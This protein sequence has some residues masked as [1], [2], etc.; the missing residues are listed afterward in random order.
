MGSHN[1]SVKL[2]CQLIVRS[3]LN[4]RIS[5]FRLGGQGIISKNATVKPSA[6]ILL[7]TELGRA[8]TILL[9]NE[10]FRVTLTNNFVRVC[11]VSFEVFQHSKSS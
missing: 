6:N 3:E 5:V 10:L 2:G 1:Q 4:V 7:K 8:I 9:D 11:Q